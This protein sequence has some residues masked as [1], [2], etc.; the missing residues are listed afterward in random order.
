MTTVARGG[1]HH[2]VGAFAGGHCA[3]M[4]VFTGIGRL[5]M[6][7]GHDKRTPARTAGV[8]RIAVVSRH[9]MGG[10]LTRSG[11][12]VMTTAALIRGLSMVKRRK[13][14]IPHIGA[15]TRLA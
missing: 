15:M 2:M 3:V 11:S 8:A 14:G 5:C 6:V 13:E 12:A 1:G 10:A 7:D 9:R 4:T